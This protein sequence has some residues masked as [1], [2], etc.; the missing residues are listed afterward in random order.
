MSLFERKERLYQFIARNFLDYDFERAE[1]QESEIIEGFNSYAQF[2]DYQR[3]N[4]D[5]LN[6]DTLTVLEYVIQLLPNIELM[7]KEGMIPFKADGLIFV[8]GK[9][10][11]TNAR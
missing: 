5:A 2:L 11:F 7:D 3:R 1:D 8:K 4:V 10:I 6:V 9:M